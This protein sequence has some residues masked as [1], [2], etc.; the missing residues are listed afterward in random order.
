MSLQ[1][2]EI[3]NQEIR[4]QFSAVMRRHPERL[5]RRL[6]LSWSNWGFG[7]ESLEES[8]KR[9]SRAGISFIELHGNHYG[10]DLGYKVDETLQVLA[11]RFGHAGGAALVLLAHARDVAVD[12]AGA[13]EGVG[14]H[15]RKARRAGVGGLLDQLAFLVN[16][17]RG[18]QPAEAQAGAENFGE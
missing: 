10:A 6:N 13:D 2:F 11:E 9:L 1:N 8:A 16:R 3:K 15:L 4:E 18:E 12:L 5:E 17:G 14:D 7:M